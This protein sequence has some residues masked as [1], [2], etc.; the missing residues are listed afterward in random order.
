M[1]EGG[2]RGLGRKPGA[3][4]RALVDLTSLAAQ[5]LMGLRDDNLGTPSCA[6]FGGSLGA[7]HEWTGCNKAWYFL[8]CPLR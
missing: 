2:E 7:P 3:S 4:L 5:G 1:S 8:F 6:R